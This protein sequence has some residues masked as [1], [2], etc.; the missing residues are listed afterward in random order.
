M[1]RS[2][3][4]AR[5]H[6]GEADNARIERWVQ[7][8][9]EEISAATEAEIEC[10]GQTVATVRRC[11]DTYA[12]GERRLR[13]MGCDWLLAIVEPDRSAVVAERHDAIL[14]KQQREAA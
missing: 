9:R 10:I 5:W 6:P 3:T 11:P 13:A 7:N 1:I 4:D 8:A 2:I 14:A 12:S